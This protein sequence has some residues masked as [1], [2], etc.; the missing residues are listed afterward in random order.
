M[1]L[2]YHSDM[3]VAERN[4]LDDCLHRLIVESCPNTY[5]YQWMT[6]IYCQNQ[7]IRIITGQLGQLMEENNAGHLQITELLLMAEYEKAAEL[8]TAHLEQSKKKTFDVLLKMGTRYT[9]G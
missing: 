7:R 4:E 8:L 5:F 6:H 3:D 1:F 2:T 9:K